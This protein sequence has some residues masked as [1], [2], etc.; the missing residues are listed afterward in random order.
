MTARVVSG[1]LAVPLV[2]FLVF[3]M[4]VHGGATWWTA[5][6]G[7]LGPDLAFLAAIGQPA[8]HGRPPA[9]AVPVYNLVHRPWLPLALLAVV[10][11]DGP[12]PAAYFV[13]GLAWLV[14]ICLDRL[15]GFGLR[16]PDGSVRR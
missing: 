11:F 10:T 2:A 4:V 3:E 13:L 5:P 6:L 8:E 14:H 1:A 9:R 15:C 7:L 12:A 16:A